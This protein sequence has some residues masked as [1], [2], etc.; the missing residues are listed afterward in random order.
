MTG[1]AAQ[2]A[3]ADGVEGADGQLPQPLTQKVI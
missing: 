1:F 2:D 3:D